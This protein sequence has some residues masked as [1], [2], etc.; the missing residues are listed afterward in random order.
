[1]NKLKIFFI[2]IAAYMVLGSSAWVKITLTHPAVVSLPG[3]I[4]SFAI[5]DRTVQDNTNSNKLE[6]VLTG[7]AFHQDEQAVRQVI[8]GIINSCSNYGKYKIIRTTERYKGNGTKNTFPT[9]LSWETVEEHCK[10]N[11]VDALLSIEIFDSDFILT[12]NPVNV[13]RAIGGNM[14][15]AVSGVVVINV[16]IRIYDPFTKTII[17]EYMVTQRVNVGGN[18]STV[19]GAANTVLNKVDAVN[20]TS[21][22]SGEVYGNRISPSYY[23]VTRE[24]FNK[25]KKNKNLLAGVRKSEVADW[26]G[27]IESWT[28]ALDD[29]KAKV[30][31]R[32]AFNIAVGYEVLGDLMKAK[33]WA[34][35]AYTEYGEKTANDYY[36]KLVRRVNEEN[37]VNYQNSG[38]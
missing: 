29:K 8:D 20:Q 5:I 33:E 26:N 36:N 15:G 31:R 35:K 3:N 27:A 16:G 21:Y 17:D 25:P 12:T 2:G 9:M 34:S 19:A 1:M 13:A 18:V 24:F 32:A 7:E 30:Q 37:V 10:K 6:Q 11:N 22:E 23:T 14:L 4:S 28:K 38:N